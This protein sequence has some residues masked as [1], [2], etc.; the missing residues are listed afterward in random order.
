[1]TKNIT[2]EL[3]QTARQALIGL[4]PPRPGDE[5]G[6]LPFRR[7]LAA[8]F[9]AR[10]LVFGTTL[11]GILVGAFLAI[12]T[13]NSYVSTGKFIFTAAGAEATR[14][15]PNRATETSQ[16]TIGTAAT[17]ILSTDELLRRVV[18]RVGP[19]KILAP[20]Q[21]GGGGGGGASAA[22]A[23]F[24]KIQR[25]WNAT[26]TD[27][28]TPEEALRQLRK[29]IAIERPRYTDVLVATCTANDPELAR[30][31]LDAYMKEAIQFHIET[32][33]DL[34][35][36]K[37]SEQGA[38]AALGVRDNAREALRKFL[39]DNQIQD[40]KIEK[41]RLQEDEVASASRV[42]KF[43]D[44]LD[45]QRRVYA[46]LTKLVEGDGAIPRY[47][48]ER[49]KL[50]VTS[51]TMEQLGKDLASFETERARLQ[52]EL[53]D[54][55]HP[56]ILDV[57]KKITATKSAMKRVAEDAMKA[58]PMEVE[59]ENEEYLQ[60]QKERSEARLAITRLEVSY[61]LALEFDRDAKAKLKRVLDLEPR[62]QQLAA[63]LQLAEKALAAA[64]ATWDAAKQ[65]EALGQGHFSS[66]KQV[67]EASL[68]LE[69]TAPNRSKLILA[70]TLVGLFLGLGLVLL[71]ALP[72]TVVRT[73]DDLE[74]IEGLAVIGVMPR[75]ESRNI[76]R[77]GYRRSR[78]W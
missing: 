49:R 75:L 44:D 3:Q 32:Y 7:L 71:M 39:E 2:D 35:A 18:D 22:R 59:V 60:A 74:G 76:K 41:E 51:G 23:F 1:M 13:A 29:T 56:R 70:A 38:T 48:T 69:K 65:K 26:K 37:A 36:Y 15:D 11:F 45:I 64:E 42:G 12:T 43:K 50:D 21:P 33:E 66:L 58:E 30:Q 57:D 73:R 47:T 54:P 8:V 40:F 4:R 53:R 62:Y 46:D 24:H 5:P 16:E 19:E 52:T 61:N 20:Y 72:D 9:R 10:Y 67:E 34:A 6:G 28:I 77:H 31:I 68:P 63:D 17:Y 25:D 14:V 55:Q 78:G 27:D